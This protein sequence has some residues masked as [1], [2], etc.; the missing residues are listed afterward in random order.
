MKLVRTPLLV[1]YGPYGPSLRGLTRP[2]SMGRY[3][4]T[5]VDPKK[6]KERRE[7]AKRRQERL[8]QLVVAWINP[9][10]T[11]GSIRGC[12]PRAPALRR[13]GTFRR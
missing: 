10:A 11:F 3:M 9:R 7:S 1:E 8:Q 2:I 12:V 6:E 13:A 4:W 5:N